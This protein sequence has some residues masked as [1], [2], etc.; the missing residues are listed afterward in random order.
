MSSDSGSNVPV[1][2]NINFSRSENGS[3]N[4]SVDD[5]FGLRAPC[6]DGLRA[7]CFRAP[8]FEGL[9]APSFNGLRAPCATNDVGSF[10]AENI[11]CGESVNGFHAAN[12]VG[13]SRADNIICGD[14]VE[15][16]TV[17][18]EVQQIPENSGRAQPEFME[19]AAD[20]VVNVDENLINEIER[21]KLILNE[22]YDD[23]CK[24]VKQKKSTKLKARWNKEK[25]NAKEHIEKLEKEITEKRQRRERGN[26]DVVE[27]DVQ[28]GEP[29]LMGA[30]IDINRIR[31]DELVLNNE[32]ELAAQV[33]ESFADFCKRTKKKKSEKLRQKWLKD[34]MSAEEQIAKN[35]K[36]RERRRLAKEGQSENVKKRKRDETRDLRNINNDNDGREAKKR[37]L[38]NM[39]ESVNTQREN[40]TEVEREARLNSQRENQNRLRENEDEEEREE[41][42]NEM[43]EAYNER[44]QNPR[45]EFAAANSENVEAFET[46]PMNHECT[47]CKALHFKG[48][49]KMKNG[50]YDSCCNGGKVKVNIGPYPE[51]LKRLM[52]REEG[53]D[54]RELDKNM[55]KYNTSLSFA[56]TKGEMRQLPGIFHYRVQ[57][58]MMHVLP[59]YTDPLPGQNP[60]FGQL[61]ILETNDAVEYRCQAPF[62]STCSREMF[63]FLHTIIE[64]KN[65]YAEIYKMLYKVEEEEKAKAEREGKEAKI[66]KIVFKKST[67]N[68]SD[69]LAFPRVN[70]VAGIYICDENGDIPFSD[71]E[72]QRKCNEG[73]RPKAEKI[74]MAYMIVDN[75]R[76]KYIRTHQKEFRV[77]SYG[78]LKD[79]LN[80]YEQRNGVR[81]GKSVVL[82]STYLMG[83]R[84]QSETWHDTMASTQKNGT[85]HWF[86]T[87]TCNPEHPDIVNNLY[88]N[89]KACD[90]PDLVDTVFDLQVKDF[91]E[92]MKSGRF[93]KVKCFTYVTE[94]QKRGLPH[95]HS[96]WTFEEGWS[97]ID[98]INQFISAEF[99]DINV[100][101]EG[102]ELVLKHMVHRPCGRYDPNAMCMQNGKCKRKFLKDFCDETSLDENSYPTYR[103][104]DDGRTGVINFKGSPFNV[105]NRSVVP[106]NMYLLKRYKC[107]IN[108]EIVCSLRSVNYLYKYLF[109]G[110]AA[111]DIEIR[112]NNEGVYDE[113]QSFLNARYLCSHE[114]YHRL[115]KF[116]MHYCSESIERL[117]VH[118]SERQTVTMPNDASEEEMIRAMMKKS[119]LLAFFELN[120]E[121]PNGVNKN[122][123]YLDVCYHF[124]WHANRNILYS[125]NPKQTELFHLRKLLTIVKGPTGYEDLRRDPNDPTVVYETFREA[126]VARGLVETDQMYYDALDEGSYHN[127]PRQL[128]GLFARIVAHCDVEAPLFLW[129]QFRRKM[130]GD[131]LSKFHGNEDL[132][133]EFAL[134]HVLRMIVN[135]ERNLEDY[136]ILQMVA[137]IVGLEDDEVDVALHRQKGDEMR[138]K[139]N[140]EQREAFE[141]IRE[142]EESGRDSAS[143]FFV[144]GPGGS[145]KSYLFNCLYYYFTGKSK[146]VTVMAWSGIAASLYETGRT[147]HNVFKLDFPFGDESNS[148]INP[149]DDLGKSLKEVDVLIWDEAPM[150]PRHALEV[151]DKKLREIMENDIPF[152]GKVMILG[153]DFRQLPPVVKSGTRNDIV[154]SS[155]KTSPLWNHFGTNTF[156]LKKNERA[157]NDVDGFAEEILKIGDGSANDNE[158]KCKLPEECI[159]DEDLIESVFRDVIDAKD[160][161][162]FASRAIIATLNSEVDAYNDKVIDMLDSETEKVYQAIDRVEAIGGE[163][164]SFAYAPEHFESIKPSGFPAYNLRLRENTVV[165]LMRNLSIKEGLCN[166]TRLLV[167]KLERNIIVAEKLTNV[168]EGEDPIVMIP[169]ITLLDESS[170]YHVYRKQFPVRP[171]FALTVHKAQGQ[172]FQK[173]AIDISKGVYVHGH[174][175]VAISRTKAWHRLKI[176]LHPDDVNR[177]RN[178]VYTEL[179]DVNPL[180]NLPQERDLNPDFRP[181]ENAEDEENNDEAMGFQEEIIDELNNDLQFQQV[182]ANVGFNEDEAYASDDE[183]MQSFLENDD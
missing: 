73:E 124:T 172:T 75:E 93:G 88:D 61:W 151:I 3:S 82:P 8:S 169:R 125:V 131:L 145:G 62:A 178:I 163:G 107:H 120:S 87:M 99:P 4:A 33:E 27:V 91:I 161:N 11:I 130:F 56:Y 181:N 9:R 63:E 65:K 43:R 22:T 160:Y 85:P 76:M 180:T 80:N 38:D 52:K 165:M 182:L 34:K 141:A 25:K 42:L 17:R 149:S 23:F 175:Y 146:K 104:R 18:E 21:L 26:N 66:C 109:K 14:G 112:A 96:L 122:L 7:N 50:A 138:E 150:A 74:I 45:V 28:S 126:C 171:A 134:R 70:E 139:L 2:D 173:I 40:E 137:E 179:L 144:D 106:Y 135:N 136:P 81:I 168:K 156:A 30:M 19:V 46:G 77:E 10:Q 164:Q 79:Y 47:K 68:T 158:G 15:V 71:I 94:F 133:E 166:G 142:K 128:R 78:G 98:K 57:G 20:E 105:D 89:Q 103:R 60:A 53:T 32:S 113:V 110:A 174:L 5:N 36:E 159:T 83:P 129:N 101:P 147:C 49:T 123:T 177:S 100:D 35:E 140:V 67:D 154:R 153:G 44:R 118:L 58:E 13:S 51:E 114:T 148:G 86:A 31:A 108:I 176:K 170:L 72:V 12:N 55:L 69:V 132:A 115:R 6:F 102:F 90:R 24:K 95:I 64:E 97:D 183:D 127:M 111:I 119:K 48:E 121:N 143:C 39:R 41:R 155:I 37:R 29:V 84:N 167:K 54:W 92:Q 152:G 117:Q 162:A 16:E 1:V 116:K 157:D 59:R